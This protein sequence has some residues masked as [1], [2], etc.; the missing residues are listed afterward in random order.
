MP[1]NTSLASQPLRLV[2]SPQEA[3]GAAL[4][5][6]VMLLQG[7]ESELLGFAEILAT[8]LASSAFTC[9][10]PSAPRLLRFFWPA[11]Y[12]SFRAQFICAPSPGWFTLPFRPGESLPK[13]S[14]SFLCVLVITSVAYGTWFTPPGLSA[15][16]GQDYLGLV[17]ALLLAPRML[18]ALR[19]H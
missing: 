1:E 4:S 18:L 19:R 5:P 13:C 17:P 15:P 10:A 11:A 2:S 3:G 9:A 12:V 8:R 16:P 14:L 6:T 7:V